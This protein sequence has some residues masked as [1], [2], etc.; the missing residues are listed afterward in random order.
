MKT[1]RTLKNYLYLLP[2]VVLIGAFFITSIFYTLYLSFYDSD[3]FSDPVFIGFDNYVELFTDSNFW[4]ST[5]NTVIWALSGLIILVAIPLILAILITKSSAPSFFK[6]AFYFPNAISLTIGGLIISAMLSIYGLPQIFG[7]LGLEDMVCN[8]LAIP[9]VNTFIM[10]LSST[11]QGIGLNLVLFIV[12]LHN[13]DSSPIE[14]ARIEGASPIQMY[15]K[16]V[17]PLLKSTTVVVM[18]MSLVNSL[19]VFDSIWVM[20]QGGPYRT[21]ETLALTM[22]LESFVRHKMGS[23]AAVAVVLTVIILIVAYFNIRNTFQKED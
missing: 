8:W 1:A 16:V 22:Y 5:M 18:L 12:G 21:S 15:V 6:N 20:T 4:I 9:Y 14:A 3:G 10:I 7:Y 13:I 19:K 17:L 11:W 2:A 23:G